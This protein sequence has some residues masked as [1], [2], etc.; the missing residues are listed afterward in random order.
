MAQLAGTQTLQC[1]LI[2]ETY[3]Y[4][5][6]VSFGG[7]VHLAMFSCNRSG[8]A[9]EDRSRLPETIVLTVMGPHQQPKLLPSRTTVQARPAS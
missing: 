6:L 3:T 9:Y 4:C 1:L 7:G 2:C 8:I 5:G